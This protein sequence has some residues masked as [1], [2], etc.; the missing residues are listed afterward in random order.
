MARLPG[1]QPSCDLLSSHQLVRPP[2]RRPPA[3]GS[4][5]E[6]GPACL[7]PDSGGDERTALATAQA[8]DCV[9]WAA[10]PGTST[11]PFPPPA[12]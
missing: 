4:I 6:G 9:F 10:P 5:G 11:L 3:S 7:L 12:G 2:H 1:S 8:R